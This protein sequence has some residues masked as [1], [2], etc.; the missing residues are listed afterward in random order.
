ML[1]DDIERLVHRLKGLRC[2]V[3]STQKHCASASMA[4]TD[5]HQ[6]IPTVFTHVFPC[7]KKRHPMPFTWM[8]DVVGGSR[9]IMNHQHG[10]G[11]C[12]SQHNDSSQ[13]TEIVKII[14]EK[15]QIRR[16]KSCRSKCTPNISK[17][18]EAYTYMS[19]VFILSFYA[20]TLSN[21]ANGFCFIYTTAAT[22]ISVMHM[23]YLRYHESI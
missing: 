23:S 2:I 11:M 18:Q 17:S 3:K 22:A 12:G 1:K 16:L 19:S 13:D 20:P 9:I 10:Y 7:S 4:S 21:S 8:D 5:V 6:Q 15:P 14:D